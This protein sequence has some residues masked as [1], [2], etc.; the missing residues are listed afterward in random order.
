MPVAPTN[1]YLDPM[2][3]LPKATGSM[4]KDGGHSESE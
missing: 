2:L 1:A 3:Y 4:F